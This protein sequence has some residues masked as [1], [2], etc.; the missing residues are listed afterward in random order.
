MTRA[1]SPLTRW[2]RETWLAC[3]WRGQSSFFC[4]PGLGRG[5]RAAGFAF[6]MGDAR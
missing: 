4:N 2:R 1:V 5:E 6:A 3:A